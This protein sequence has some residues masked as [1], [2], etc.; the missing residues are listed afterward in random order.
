MRTRRAVS[1]VVADEAIVVPV[2]DDSARAGGVYTFN[3]SGTAIW[4]MV[5]AGSSAAE[6]A[7]YL[8]SEYGISAEQ[9]AEDTREFLA[10]LAQEGLVDLA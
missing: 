1:Q 9:A 6:V 4:A 8:E 7:A 5:E 3:E 10:S 2:G